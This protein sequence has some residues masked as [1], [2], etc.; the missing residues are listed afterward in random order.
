MRKAGTIKAFL[1][2]ILILLLSTSLCA[3]TRELIVLTLSDLHGQLEPFVTEKENKTLKVGGIARIASTVETIKNI[4]PDK[5]VLFSSGDSLTDKY[6]RQ[7]DG[8]A[9]FSSASL[10]GIDAATLGNHE[11]DRGDEALSNALIYCNFPIIQSNLE[12]TDGN[13]LKNSFKKFK[14]IERNN[15]KIGIIGLMTPDLP[16]ISS[17]GSD[18]K[19]NTDLVESAINTLNT[20]KQNEK[21]DLIVALTHL[22][23]EEDIMLAEKVPEIDLICGGHSH[24]FMKKDEEIIVSHANGR[25]TLIIHSGARGEYLGKLDMLV[26]RGNIISHSW[27]PVRITTKIKQDKKALALIMVYKNQL[28]EKK[29]LTVLEKALDC[30]GEILR[31]KEA[32]AG[33]LITDIIRKHF[34]TDIVFLNGGGIRGERIIPSGSITTEDIDLMLP[35]KNQITILSLK[36]YKIKQALEQSASFLPLQYGGFLQ[37]SGISFDIDVNEEPFKMEPHTKTGSIKIIR[38]GNRV[39]KIMILDING[40]YIPINPDKTYQAAV[41]SFLANGGDNY[42]ILKNR[43]KCRHILPCEVLLKTT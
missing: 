40:K 27:N 2:I 1:A 11:F 39:S 35:F 6:F 26:D 12:I 42:F 10:I 3:E 31:T 25:K 37:V 17:A 8:E 24:N 41:N 43:K 33:N 21:P 9:I 13:S 30:R 19:V 4:N 28:P 38:T 22:G 36:G 16:F 23:L 32:A 7:F 29:V 18:I 34:K 15:I 5:V 14:I 20:L